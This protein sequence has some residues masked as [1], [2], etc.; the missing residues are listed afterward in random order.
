MS[1]GLGDRPDEDVSLATESL[2][3]E[4][5]EIQNGVKEIFNE[6]K[7]AAAYDSAT[8]A[9]GTFYKGLDIKA[10][11][12]GLYASPATSITVQVG[13]VMPRP[14]ENAERPK[15]VDISETR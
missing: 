9:A 11:A 12:R 3:A 2:I 8:R 6:T 15:V 7:E 5:D 14:T 4:L 13:I 10:K 1:S